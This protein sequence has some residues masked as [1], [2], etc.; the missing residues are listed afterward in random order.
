MK[1]NGP[2]PTPRSLRAARGNP[3]HRP[4]PPDRIAPTPGADPPSSM[5]KEGKA[6]WARLEVELLRLGLLTTIDRSLFASYCEAWSEFVWATEEIRREGRVTEAG[7]GTI[8]PHPA[9]GIR[10]R[11]AELMRKLA[12]NFGFSPADRM[13]LL[14]EGSGDDDEQKKDAAFFGPRPVPAPRK[15]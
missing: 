9:V 6:E 11:A 12:A 14:L 15:T 4:L 7:N 5:T 10:T 3:G 1:V 13:R 8:I 2:P